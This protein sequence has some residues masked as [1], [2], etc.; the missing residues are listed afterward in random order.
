MSGQHAACW[1]DEYSQGVVV[2]DT[3]GSFNGTFLRLSNERE[4][5]RRIR[6]RMGTPFLWAMYGDSDDDRRA[7]R[8]CSSS[9]DGT[10]R[11]DATMD[12]Q[13]TMRSTPL[14][15]KMAAIE[16]SFNR[17]GCQLRLQRGWT[18]P[19]ILMVLCRC[20]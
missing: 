2:A 16:A 12:R 15:T 18:V 10:L 1:W 17:G 14:K 5:S 3:P 19:S 6:S 11:P 8:I 9:K 20:D 7:Y 4:P 13:A